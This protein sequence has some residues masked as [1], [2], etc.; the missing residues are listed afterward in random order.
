MPRAMITGAQIR[1][2]RAFAKISAAE[3]A[4]LA[5]IGKM[6][7]FRAELSDG[8][9]ATTA[10]NLNAIQSALE[11]LGAVFQEDGGVNFVLK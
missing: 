8:V 6:T 5:H 10:A 7:V 1:A 2:A 3:L 11:K 9:P 4:E